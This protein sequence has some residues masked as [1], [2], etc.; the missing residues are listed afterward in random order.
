MYSSRLLLHL[1]AEFDKRD[2]KPFASY[3]EFQQHTIIFP[4]LGVYFL[5]TK[6]PVLVVNSYHLFFKPYIFQSI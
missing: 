3:K 4:C 2:N 1:G 6:G 5:R